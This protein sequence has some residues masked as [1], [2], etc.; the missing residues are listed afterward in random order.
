MNLLSRLQAHGLRI[1]A[2]GGNLKISPREAI[3]D[4]LLSLIR[5]HK[6]ELLQE[7]EGN[8]VEPDP[9]SQVRAELALLVAQAHAKDTPADRAEAL[10][11][12][13]QH[14][15]DALLYYRW[16]LSPAHKDYQRSRRVL[17]ALQKAEF[18][19][20]GTIH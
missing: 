10:E 13:L 14:P 7:V 18:L 19:A 1:R 16:L 17:A 4:E 2:E 3:T 5:D 6:A 11:H 12:A 8:H 9:A 20:T 15:V